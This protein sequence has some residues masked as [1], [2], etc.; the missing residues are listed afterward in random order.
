MSSKQR[1]VLT[2]VL[3]RE[4]NRVLLGMKKRGFGAGKWNGF[5]GK[6]EAGETVVE[7]AAREVRE[8]CGYDVPRSNIHQIQSFPGSVGVSGERRT[9]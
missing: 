4:D 6:L 7:A 5:G 8:E 9:M 3:L 2:L 1:K